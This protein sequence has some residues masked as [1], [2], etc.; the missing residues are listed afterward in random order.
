MNKI[1]L[2]ALFGESGSGKDTIQHWL[3]NNIPNTHKIV[4]CTTRPPR[5][6]E[7]DGVDYYFLTANDFIS[8]YLKNEILDFTTFNDWQYGT[9]KSDLKD[10]KIN[11]GIFNIEGIHDLLNYSNGIEILPVYIQVDEKT[12][13]LRTLKREN[14]PDCEEICRRFL[15][16]KKDF[17][18]I[19]FDYE[20]FL[21]DKDGDSYYGF[22]KRPKIEQF[23]KGQI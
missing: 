4:S 16:D 13:L 20:I 2:L 19:D 18:N 6:Y 9:L 5:E 17:K 22:L 12:R 7:K 8:K 14:N 10:D 11:I 1:K 15:A 3:A 23:L 21:N